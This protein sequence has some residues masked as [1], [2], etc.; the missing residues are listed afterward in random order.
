[1]CVDGDPVTDSSSASLAM[2]TPARWDAISATDKLRTIADFLKCHP[3]PLMPEELASLAITNAD[4]LEGLTKVQPSAKREGFATVPGVT[5][6]DIGALTKVREELRMAVVE[7]IRNPEMFAQVGITAPAGVLLWGP[8]GNGKTLLAK[9]IANESHTNFISVKGGELMSKYVGD[10]ERAVRQVFSRARASSPC[11]IFFDELDALCSRRS[12][13]Q[14]EASS[15]VVNTLL[16]EIDGMES[17][18]SVYVIAATNRPDIIDPAMLRPGRLDKL[19]FVELPTPGERA[20]ILRT[21]SKRTP[22][23]DDVCLE[24]IATHERCNRFSGA[25]L[26]GLIRE[27]SVAALRSV[28]F[29]KPQSTGEAADILPMKPGIVVTMKNFNDALLRTTPSVSAEDM[30]QYESMRKKYGN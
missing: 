3:D 16:T 22:L 12:G 18:K 8:P 27:A 28:F 11:V 5:W 14:S 26:A 25:D 15:R 29:D 2:S 1:M 9:A 10:S 17:R 23:A 6:D 7:P 30:R 13:D 19:L 4:F 21:L 24:S 20:D